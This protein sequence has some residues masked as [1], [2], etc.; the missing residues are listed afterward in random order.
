MVLPKIETID[1]KF[2]KQIVNGEKSH[3]TNKSFNKIKVERFE[4]FTTKAALSM[5]KQDNICWK[6]VPENWAKDKAKI[7]REFLW[8]VLGTIRSD[9]IS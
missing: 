3:M 1:I 6:F 9:F 7:D 5:C 8:W 2:L 4:E